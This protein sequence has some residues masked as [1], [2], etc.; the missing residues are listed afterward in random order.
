MR[1]ER[2]LRRVETERAR[3]AL[4]SQNQAI[5][6]SN[7]ARGFMGHEKL[8]HDCSLN[9]MFAE[10]QRQIVLIPLR[11]NNT[12]PFILR[13]KVMFFFFFFNAISIPGNERSLT[14]SK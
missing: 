3:L 13:E 12:M 10:G 5:Q 6:L 1:Y 2:C 8:T 7:G 11:H 4:G 14:Y 9:L